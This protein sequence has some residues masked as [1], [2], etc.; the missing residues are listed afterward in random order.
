VSFVWI[1]LQCLRLSVTTLEPVYVVS[2]S[3]AHTA[4]RTLTFSR[5]VR[6]NL[7]VQ[8]GFILLYIHTVP[9]YAIQYNM[10]TSVSYSC[11]HTRVR[12]GHTQRAHA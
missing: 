10:R 4:R 11:L 3:Y 2:I 5:L 1:Y 7:K 9:W 6:L 8:F 12:G